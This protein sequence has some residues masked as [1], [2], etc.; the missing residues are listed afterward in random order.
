MFALNKSPKRIPTSSTENIQ[1]NKISMATHND[2]SPIV[3]TPVN[4]DPFRR[5]TI[6]GHSPKKQTEA[7]VSRVS[8]NS[9]LAPSLLDSPLKRK[10]DS[11]INRSNDDIYTLMMNMNQQ[12]NNNF[13]S[14]E[15]KITQNFSD[16]E[17][18][19]KTRM[20]EVDDK[21]NVVD[22]KVNNNSK[23]INWLQQERLQNKM[24]IDGLKFSSSINKS[25]V[26]DNTVKF[27]QDVG[28]KVDNSDIK[29][30]HMKYVSISK[31]DKTT[32]PIV[33]VEFDN[34]DAKIRV[35]QAK[36][37][38][39]A[40]PGVFFD[41]CLTPLNRSLM[42]KLKKVTKPKN[43]A[44]YIR[45]NKI[46]AKKNDELFKAIECEEDIDTVAEW[47]GNGRLNTNAQIDQSSSSSS[48]SSEI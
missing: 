46:Y 39:N 38:T 32:K 23:L 27:L 12:M 40:C 7:S 6:T 10:S 29:S 4:V 37:S 28:I 47:P 5:T 18:R 21:V 25:D 42:G 43:F 30:A 48:S 24:E 33:V 19:L 13:K 2:A 15:A 35:M 36:R 11:T 3:G 9:G 34:L 41:N 45:N 14:I 44:V 17:A 16:M 20:D 31:T 22:V 26:K 8:A 1:G